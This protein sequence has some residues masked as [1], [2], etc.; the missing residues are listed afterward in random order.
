MSD[1][2]KEIDS[3][4]ESIAVKEYYKHWELYKTQLNGVSKDMPVWI[5][6]FWKGANWQKEKDAERIKLLE[7]EVVLLRQELEIKNIKLF[8]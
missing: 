8:K 3:K 4:M 6:A 7:S 5:P 1:Y 2:D